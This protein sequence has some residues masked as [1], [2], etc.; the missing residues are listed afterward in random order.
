MNK[1]F[2]ASGALAGLILTGGLTGMVSA[3]SAATAT[4]LTEA[5]VIEIALMEVPGEVT[6]VEQ[7]SHRGKGIFEVEI[8][9]ADGTEMEVEIAADTGEVLK[10]KAEGDDCDKDG[11]GKDGYDDDDNEE[12]G[13][14]A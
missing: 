7:E 6:E 10:V 8:L 3:Q 9:A 1:N 11:R 14:D 12:E 4:G 5:Q 2:I 13:E